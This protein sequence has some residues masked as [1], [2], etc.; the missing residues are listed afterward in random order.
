[1]NYESL[2][3]LVYKHIQEQITKG[4][5]KSGERIKENEI[6]ESMGISRTPIR[7]ALIKLEAE[8][9]VQILSR[10]GFIVKELTLNEFR[11]IYNIIGCL[12]GY[13]ASRVVSKITNKDFFLFRK[14]ADSMIKAKSDNKFY[15]FDKNNVLFHNIYLEANQNKLI[16]K[17]VS[18]LKKRIYDQRANLKI[19]PEWYEKA[20]L[21]HETIINLFEQKE[22]DK[23]EK[24]LRDV[25]WNFEKNLLFVKKAFLSFESDTE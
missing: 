15:D 4:N 19:I 22:A 12:E 25:H 14:I 16:F 7:E 3:D 6:C 21:E 17:T 13:A 9:F 18:L 5:L 24:Y 20:I 23:I 10:R 8:G 11:N 1:M 2:S